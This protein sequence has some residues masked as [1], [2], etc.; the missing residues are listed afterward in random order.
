MLP[1]DQSLVDMV[2]PDKCLKGPRLGLSL[3]YHLTHAPQANLRDTIREAGWGLQECTSS[4]ADSVSE[5]R[6]GAK[7]CLQS[8][9]VR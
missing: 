4:E 5:G 9:V 3:H 2:H 1:V 8:E 6:V 7:H